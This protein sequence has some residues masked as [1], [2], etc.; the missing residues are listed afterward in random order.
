MRAKKFARE[1][2]ENRTVNEQK[3][4]KVVQRGQDYPRP[5]QVHKQ[6]LFFNIHPFISEKTTIFDEKQLP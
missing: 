5:L 6:I 1:Y 3:G 2:S 4:G